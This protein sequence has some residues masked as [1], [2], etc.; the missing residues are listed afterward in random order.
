[1]SF[2]KYG[3]RNIP[4]NLKNGWRFLPKGDITRNIYQSEYHKNHSNFLN[5]FN[6]PFYTMANKILV[7]QKNK[8]KEEEW[9]KEGVKSRKWPEKTFVYTDKRGPAAETK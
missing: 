6:E 5:V 7:S 2:S 4:I 1:M 9:M 3:F 8:E